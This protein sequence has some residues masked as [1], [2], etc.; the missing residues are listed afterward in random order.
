MEITK[1]VKPFIKR[2][3]LNTFGNI[4]YIKYIFSVN[5]L[6]WHLYF[7]DQRNVTILNTT[8]EYQSD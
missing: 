6:L 4:V 2:G 8:A 7:R 3:W 1:V 5:K